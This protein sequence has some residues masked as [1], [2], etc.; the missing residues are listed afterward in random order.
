MSNMAGPLH[1]TIGKL[2]MKRL[3]ISV[4]GVF[5]VTMLGL[6]CGGDTGK[7]INSGKDKPLPVKKDGGEG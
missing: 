3:L 7:G 4:A 2:T 5:L 6:G 1:Y